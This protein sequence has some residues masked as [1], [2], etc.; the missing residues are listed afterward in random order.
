[1]VK[2]YQNQFS[3]NGTVLIFFRSGGCKSE[4][5][6]VF[7][8]TPS[9]FQVLLNQLLFKFICCLGSHA[10]YKTLVCVAFGTKF[11]KAGISL[12]LNTCADLSRNT[13]HAVSSPVARISPWVGQQ[14]I[15]EGQ[16]AGGVWGGA[17]SDLNSPPQA[18]SPCPSAFNEFGH[19]PTAGT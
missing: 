8:H 7:M 14:W 16:G 19:P 5:N 18:A 17:R 11:L 10:H 1:M 6:Y 2:C 12:K 13:V 4:K 3:N 15:L 9:W